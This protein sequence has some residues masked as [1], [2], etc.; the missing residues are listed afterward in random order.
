TED[1]V[2]G[3]VAAHPEH[4]RQVPG[5][6]V[7]AK[8]AR[9]GVRGWCSRSATTPATPPEGQ[10]TAAVVAKALHAV[11][12]LLHGKEEELGRAELGDKTLVDALIPFVEEL[13][14]AVDAGEKAA[15]T[16]G[17]RPPDVSE[18]HLRVERD[19]A[20]RTRN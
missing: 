16:P 3:F 18:P 12:E 1:M 19:G 7:R 8:R 5:G 11:A 15:G 4:V 10:A 20:V 14:R 2:T 17:S 13:R 9:E 6:V